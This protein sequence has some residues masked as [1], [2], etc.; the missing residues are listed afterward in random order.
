MAAAMPLY[1]GVGDLAREG[2]W[3]QWGGERLYGDGFTRMPG[4]RARFTAVPVPEVTIPPGRFHLTTRR[5]KQFNSMVQGERDFV[6][7]SSSR[8]DVLIHPADASRLGVKDGDRLRLR[9]E[10]GEWVGV[11]RLAAMKERHLQTYWPETNVLIPRRFDPVSGE[12]DYNVMVTAE[13][14]DPGA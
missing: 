11:A 10:V 5:G 14:A 1:A 8:H 7:G 3:V 6:M 4:G 2:Q 13:R 9:S 12:P